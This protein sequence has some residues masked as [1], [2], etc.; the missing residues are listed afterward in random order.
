MVHSIKR[1][2]SPFL[3]NYFDVSHGDT[4][5]DFCYCRIA[6]PSEMV[7]FKP[8]QNNIYSGPKQSVAWVVP[9]HKLR[10]KPSKVTKER[11]ITH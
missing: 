8:T 10:G 11:K 3:K 7:P 2:P 1:S 6:P 9:S 5:G 4:E